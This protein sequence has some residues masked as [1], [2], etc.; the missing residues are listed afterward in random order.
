MEALDDDHICTVAGLCLCGG[1]AVV[2]MRTTFIFFTHKQRFCC[3]FVEK[4]MK[5]SRIAKKRAVATSP[6]FKDVFQRKTVRL[7]PM[8]VALK[9]LLLLPFPAA[10]LRKT[11]MDLIIHLH[12]SAT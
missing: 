6:L 8:A 12:S 2:H 10:G 4:R 5:G 11:L 7:L 9:Q 1:G 3:F